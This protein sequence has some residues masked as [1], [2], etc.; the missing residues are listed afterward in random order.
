MQSGVLVL[1]VFLPFVA[2]YYLSFL[3]KTINAT[4]GRPAVVGA[5]TSAPAILAC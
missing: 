5:S 3:F 1:R 4:I 2:A